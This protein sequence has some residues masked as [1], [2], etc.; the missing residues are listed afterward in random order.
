[1]RHLNSAREQQGGRGVAGGGA[2][3]PAIYAQQ[4]Q[5]STR[6]N[7]DRLAEG[8]AAA[9]A[10]A[11]P[12]QR[13]PLYGGWRSCANKQGGKAPSL[14]ARTAAAIHAPAQQYRRAR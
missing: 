9:D 14:R 13:Q 7:R 11:V 4:L 1:V 6:K 2:L 10:P 5:T 8:R 12:L 3:C